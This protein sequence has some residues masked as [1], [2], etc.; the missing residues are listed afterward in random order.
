MDHNGPAGQGFVEV[1]VSHVLTHGGW[2]PQNFI[3]VR[4]IYVVQQQ[5]QQLNF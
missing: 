4:L 3:L 5:Q 2:R 1:V